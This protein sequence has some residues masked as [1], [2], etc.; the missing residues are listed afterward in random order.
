MMDTVFAF[1][2]AYPVLAGGI[3]TVVFGSMMYFVRG[4]PLWI[5]AFMKRMLTIEISLTS[6]S[7]LYHE[8]LDILSAS[9]VGMLA[10]CYAT[11]REGDLVSGFGSSVAKFQRKFV[12]FT[13][14]LIANNLRLDEKLS[15]TLFTRDVKVLRSMIAKARMPKVDD[16][17]KIYSASSGGYWH[18]PIKRRRRDLGTV[19]VNGDIKSRIVARIQWFLDNEDWYARRGIPYKLVFLLHGPPGTG[20]SSLIYSVASTFSRGIGSLTSI[21]CIDETLRSLPENTFAAIEDID[22]LAIARDDDDDEVSPNAPAPVREPRSSDT[23]QQMSALQMLI[24]TLDGFATP[25]GLVLFVTTNHRDR[26]DQTLLRS[27]R[28]DHDIEVGPLDAEATESMFV[29][30][31]GDT[32]QGAVG[33]WVSSPKFRPRTGA[34]LQ[35]LFM[36][37]DAATAIENLIDSP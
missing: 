34:D 8:M 7:F 24:N 3:G 18:S 31:Y 22:L 4:I 36:T 20:K 10:R 12:L 27:S 14:E 28:I 21:T 37:A 13:R 35:S 1:A 6:E 26:L 23:A 9:R 2:K 32:C 16:C 17:I 30:F 15:V 5:F 19:F 33:Q 29:T 25:H 11:D